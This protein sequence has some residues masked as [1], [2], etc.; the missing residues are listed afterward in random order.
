MEEKH[1]FFD[2]LIKNQ[3][4]PVLRL[5]E[6]SKTSP[7]RKFAANPADALQTLAV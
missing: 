6:N 3:P 4:D 2:F 7:T 1:N 5:G